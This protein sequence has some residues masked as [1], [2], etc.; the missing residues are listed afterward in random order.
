MRFASLGSG[1]AGNAL[2]VEVHGTK[3]LLDCGFNL[4]ETDLRLA[5]LGLSA[6]EID[7]ILVTHEHG[8]H[9]GGV[10]KLAARNNIPVWLTH[11]TYKSIEERLEKVSANF[12]II[13]SHT[14]VEIGDIQIHPFPVPH[15][16]KEPIQFTFTDGA[17]KLGILTDTGRSTPHIEEMLSLCDAL[18]LECNHD[19]NMLKNGTYPLS[20]KERV[21]SNYGHLD[22]ESAAQLLNKLNNSRLKHLIAAHLSEKNNTPEL[23]KRSLAVAIQC[24]ENW[25]ETA[26]QQQGFYWRAL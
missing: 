20:L 1:S 12:H 19:L 13:D 4:K 10:P 18:V 21:S 5:R 6:D 15:D 3:V 9:A 14:P 24:E 25:I 23:A 11:G 26:S 22:N 8:D 16:A 2:I 17:K 7:A